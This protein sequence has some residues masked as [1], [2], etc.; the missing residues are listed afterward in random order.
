MK[1]FFLFFLMI[2]LFGFAAFPV[3]YDNDL[4]ITN[5]DKTFSLKNNSV[6]V[7]ATRPIKPMQE[8]MLTYKFT[9]DNVKSVSVSSNMEMNMG[10]FEYDGIKISGNEFVVKQILTKCMSGR[11]K[12]YSKAAITYNDNTKDDLYIF[13]DVK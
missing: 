6:T 13:F 3:Q 12:W 10:K 4:D 2:P 9:N 7:S 1:K 11:T 8:F 5:A